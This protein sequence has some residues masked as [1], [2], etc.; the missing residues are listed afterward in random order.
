MGKNVI[1]ESGWS[2]PIFR[3]VRMTAAFAAAAFWVEVCIVAAFTIRFLALGAGA[4]PA[5]RTSSSYVSYAALALRNAAL[6]S[7]VIGLAVFT[8]LQALLRL[9]PP[10]ES[11]HRKDGAPTAP[12]AEAALAFSAFFVLLYSLGFLLPADY[13][14]PRQSLLVAWVLC[15]CGYLSFQITR[16]LR[17]GWELP[18]RYT[19]TTQFL[20]DTAV[21]LG[22]LAAAYV[23]RFDGSFPQE[24][25]AQFLVAG[26]YV[27]AAYQASNRLWG[28]H[29]FVWRFTGLKDVLA[30]GQAVAST[31]LAAMLV[32]IL[33]LEEYPTLRIPFGV[34][35]IQPLLTFVGL[36]AVRGLRRVQYSYSRS[37]QEQPSGDAR[38]EPE[39]RCVLLVGAGEAGR[40]LVRELE[41]RREF[42]IAG[43]LDDDPHKQNRRVE[44]I[45]VLGGIRDLRR[46]AA[47]AGVREVVLSMPSAPQSVMRRVVADCEEI[48]LKVWSVPSV[49]EVLLG[50]V[51]VGRLRPVRMEDLL[52]RA[53]VRFPSED[54]ELV[55]TYEGKRILVTGAAGSIGSEL[56]RQ[57]RDYRPAQLVLLDKDESGLYE[58]G[59]EL[60]EDYGGDLVEVVADIRD[61]R[62]L[63]QVFARWQPQ[64]VFHAAA[65]KHVPMME[66]HPTEA[67][68]NNIFGTQNVVQAASRHGAKF[69]LLIS[70]DKAVNPTSVMGASK[71]VAEMIVRRE[72]ANNLTMRCCCVRFG[73]VL[74][75]RASVVPLFQKR[76]AEGRNIQVTHPEVRR[77]FMTIPEAVQLVLQAGSLAR[78]GETFV[79]DM[80]DPV[81][82]VDLARELIA[83]SG[84]VLGQD[85]EIEF[86]G[87]RP[88]EKLYEELLISEG[89][90]STKY[91]KIFVDLPP[92]RPGEELEAALRQL[93]EAADSGCPEGIYE[94]FR[95]LGIGYRRQLE[96]REVV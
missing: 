36:V 40:L 86:T 31:A 69:L 45:R 51:S 85:I 3:L 44:G 8:G 63:D 43:F 14:F 28:V 57:L 5:A 33:F 54:R 17:S 2:R 12:P 21:I 95:N 60:R 93:Q 83:Q 88:G 38:G 65:Y 77:Y 76:I 52:G 74:G 58:K 79:L 61:P 75:S 49:S 6:P 71:R 37:R 72:A 4:N 34:L 7:L 10:A 9:R 62:R 59:L 46:I 32:R 80:G 92:E 48:G 91:P 41:R 82:I 94:A 27:L 35:I 29:S 87:L 84:L 30:I 53:S 90:R 78:R 42:S 89:Q 26:P 73:N 1:R 24:Q 47:A 96:V 66:H 20:I 70:T 81:R 18:L 16:H 56:V 67:V 25:L 39:L 23:V 13:V 19:R 68:R 64:A 22:A 15:V 55:A 50:K 11:S